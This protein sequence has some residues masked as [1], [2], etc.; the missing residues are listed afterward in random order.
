MAAAAADCVTWRSGRLSS[1]SFIA[2]VS[3]K[4]PEVGYR[5]SLIQEGPSVQSLWN[6]SP[7]YLSTRLAAS[8]GLSA[9]MTCWKDDMSVN[10]LI[11]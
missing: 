3:V 8:L 9:E 2:A 10:C 1:S 11:S 7:P 6:S 4:L 5:P